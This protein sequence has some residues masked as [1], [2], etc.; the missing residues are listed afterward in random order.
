MMS[1]MKRGPA[2]GFTLLEIVIVVSIIAALSTVAI[3][4]FLNMVYTSKR[5]ETDMMFYSIQH[6]VLDYLAQNNDHFPNDLG[7]GASN[8]T[9]AWNPAVFDGAKK[10]W[11][12]GQ[13]GWNQLMWEPL[14]YVYHSYYLFAYTSPNLTYF[15]IKAATDL[16]G[17][18][19]IAIRTQEWQRYG[20]DWQINSDTIDPPNEW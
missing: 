16:D 11:L 5:S 19:V 13:P 20:Q 1:R 10:P 3:P 4:G 8:L 17:N 7:G 9:T 2:A 12:T 18:G 14:N 6:A 15:T